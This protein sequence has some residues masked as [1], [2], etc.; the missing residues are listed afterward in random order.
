MTPVWFALAAS[1]GA[2]GRH[3]VHQLA[4][5]WTALLIV[6]VIGSF[7]LGVVVEADLS[8][9]TTTVLGVAFCGALTT[10]SGFALEFRHLRPA[11]AVAFAVTMVVATCAAA[12]LGMLAS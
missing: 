5:T 6:N 4:R 8:A 3:A 1:C 12:A 7:L 9:P 11:P 2:L 10:Y